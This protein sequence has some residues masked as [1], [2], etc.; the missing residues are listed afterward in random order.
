[1]MEE[2]LPA[3]TRTNF[4]TGK[5]K[6]LHSAQKFEENT[7]KVEVSLSLNLQLMTEDGPRYS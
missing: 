7:D 5:M 6:I 1:M 3:L 4:I 2:S